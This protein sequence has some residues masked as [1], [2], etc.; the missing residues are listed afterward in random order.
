ME[1]FKIIILIP[2]YNEIDKLEIVIR[3]IKKNYQNNFRIIVADDCSDDGTYEWLKNNKIEFLRSNKRKGYT[4]N[5]ISGMNHIIKYAYKSEY[6]LTMDADGE[7]KVL[8]LDKIMSLVKNN[9]DVDLFVGNRDKKNRFFETILGFFFKIKFGIFDPLCGFKLYRINFVQKHLN[10][11]SKNYFLLDFIIY[12]K[13]ENLNMK[14]FN[15]EVSKRLGN[16][17]IGNFITS[18]VKILN[19]FKLIFK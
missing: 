19:C 14:N 9:L 15:I 2:A 3:D 12:A 8:N 16:S 10:I 6:L 13:K 7:H 5:L 11:I 1:E 17:R 4:E 18:N